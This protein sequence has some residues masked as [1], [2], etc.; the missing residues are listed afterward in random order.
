MLGVVNFGKGNGV[1]GRL[2]KLTNLTNLQRL[3]VTGLTNKEGQELCKSIGE[4]SR[5]Q[6]LEVRSDSLE[7]LIMMDESAIPRH[8][9]SLRLCGKVSMLPEWIN[10]LND[11][12][13]VKLLGTELKQEDILCLQNLR[14]LTLLGLWENFYIGKSLHF[15]AG[16][17]PKLKFLDID[18]QPGIQTIEIENGAMP[19]LEQLWV[20]KCPSLHGLSGVQYLLNLN[21]LL[22]KNCGEK[23]NLIEILQVQVNRH[24]RRPKFLIGSR[25]R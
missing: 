6:Q 23:R 19:E 18:R 5:L 9:V 7:F 25:F 8:L 2:K 20:N 14:N 10:S 12:A 4:F 11:L 22:L 15:T 1:V 24:I 17:F 3:G 21:E 13:K 16:K